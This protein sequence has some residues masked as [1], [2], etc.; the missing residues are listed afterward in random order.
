MATLQ[1]RPA[2]ASVP[3]YKAGKPPTAGLR[4]SYKLSSN[5]NPFPPLPGVIAAATRAV[6]M[7]NRYP[8]MG[9]SRLHAALADRWGVE[10]SQIASGAGSVAVLY[11]LLQAACDDGD[12]VVYAW[13]SFEA[14][15]IAVGL[16]GARSVQVPVDTAGRHDLDAMAA[17]VTDKT[18]AVLVCTPNNPTGPAVRRDELVRFLDAVPASVLVAI[19]EAYHEFID[20]P[21]RVDGLEVAR[22]RDNVVVLR[23][24]SKAYGLAGLRVGYAVGA[25]GVAEAVRKCALPF[26]VSSVAQAAALA[27]LECEAQLMERVE[28]LVVERARVV[29]ALQEQGWKLP[30][31]QGNFV[32][33]PLGD[34]TVAFAAATDE[35]GVSVR[36]FA[37]D[38]V[39]VT[40]GEPEANDKF[41]AVAE[42]WSPRSA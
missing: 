38:G 19:D 24:F 6:E 29:A 33:L 27:S 26:G 22:G 1:F 8:D 25:P 9:V 4:T 34:D 30:D 5:E 18:R 32:W 3:A 17:A 37:G 41:L 7:L 20:D 40:I 14:Y 28:A 35:A 11:Q 2:L 36:P 42:Q 15:P 16:T 21:E 10:P 23:T 31:A 12:E 13:R 39:R